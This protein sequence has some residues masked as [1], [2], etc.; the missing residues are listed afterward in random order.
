VNILNGLNP[1][2]K[3]HATADDT[4]IMGDIC[5]TSVTGYTTFGTINHGVLFGVDGGLFVAFP[6]DGIMFASR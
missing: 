1:C 4:W 3:Q 2:G 5:G 6:N